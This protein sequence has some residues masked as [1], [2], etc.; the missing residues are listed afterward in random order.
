MVK[1]KKKRNPL[2]FKQ[3]TRPR[4]EFMDYDYVHKL[5]PEEK[6]FLAKFTDEYYGG[7]VKKGCKTD[8][9]YSPDKK[10]YDRL[11]K[12]CYNRN[13]RQN[14][15]TYGLSKMALRLVDIENDVA[16]DE[17][18]KKASYIN[19]E[20]ALIEVLDSLAEQPSQKTGDKT[21]AGSDDTEL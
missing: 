10:E 14:I 9:H 2:N 6:E 16:I 1:K 7:A 3:Q 18:D 11:R 21:D 19:F 8:I 4:R 12:D 13:N 15:D 17:L 5:S 20:D